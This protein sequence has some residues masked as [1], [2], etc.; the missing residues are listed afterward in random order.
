[1]PVALKNLV[2]VIIRNAVFANLLLVLVIFAGLLATFVMVR[3]V[4]PSF[5]IETIQVQVPYHG[6]G[7]EEVEEGVC[8]KIEDAI[9]GITG[10]KRYVTV[11]NEGMGMAMIDVVEGESVR[12]VKD[13][14]TDRINAVP[15]WPEDAE[16]PMVTELEIQQETVI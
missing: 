16:R 4:F 8:L 11:A 13:R 5:E 3:E 14:I 15:N 7:P 2:A 6:A 1:R 9:E 12:D 10:I